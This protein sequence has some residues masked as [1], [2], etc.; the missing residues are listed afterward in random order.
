MRKNFFIED[1]GIEAHEGIEAVWAI[2]TPKERSIS[3]VKKILVGGIYIA[4][5]SQ[6]KQ[7]TV[8]HIVQSMFCAQSRY[9]SPFFFL[10]LEILTKLTFKIYWRAMEHCSKCAMW[11]LEMNQP[12]NW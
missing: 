7:E 1:A 3:N 12:L 4:P 11:P 6:Y 5:R 2:L 9:D 8:D 10:Y